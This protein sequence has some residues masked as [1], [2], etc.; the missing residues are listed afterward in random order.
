MSKVSGTDSL[1]SL[2]NLG[3][4]TAQGKGSAEEGASSFAAMLQGI[5]AEG[6][7]GGTA[8]ILP[9][10]PAATTTAAEVDTAALTT[11]PADPA[12]GA[13][14]DAAALATTAT[15]SADSDADVADSMTAP[16]TQDAV[17]FFEDQ[18]AL[19]NRFAAAADGKTPTSKTSNPDEQATHPALRTSTTDS[20]EP[21][22]AKG[23]KAA[24]AAIDAGSAAP[25][26]EVPALKASKSLMALADHTPEH[27]G[28]A[29]PQD[30]SALPAAA[31]A[32]TL[33]DNSAN[34]ALTSASSTNPRDTTRSTTGL[35]QAATFG[36]NSVGNGK[37]LPLSGKFLSNGKEHS[38]KM[39]QAK[40]E[41]PITLA[42]FTEVSSLEDSGF[43]F[44]DIASSFFTPADSESAATVPTGSSATAFDINASSESLVEGSA[45]E[46]LPESATAMLDS[47]S[48][49]GSYA[50]V[51][52]TATQLSMLHEQGV[53]K[54]HIRLHPEELGSL[55]VTITVN[56]GQAYIQFV[57]ATPEAREL[58]QNS[59][60]NLRELLQQ[61]GLALAE[62]N[63][64]Q[65]DAQKDQGLEQNSQQG[66]HR[67]SNG[68]EQPQP[69]SWMRPAAQ[70]RS[71]IDYYI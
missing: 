43:S 60:P 11:A 57:T 45:P 55:D 69:H 17:Q 46:L 62:G 41:S 26:A 42:G 61:S 20:N 47:E 30:A 66:Q 15:T 36:A 28:E 23:R 4:N 12:A 3:L 1:G 51:E 32:A 10:E 54:A 24:S 65:G 8:A 31:S 52:D 50:W 38:G 19:H 70:S 48:T 58:L 33:A 13:V 6:D 25:A 35:N 37:G 56:E 27:D 49:M 7:A 67:F 59:L 5:P 14:I 29:E 22:P 39:T 16:G 21:A 9:E 68:N 44:E 71:Q 40:D 2:L 53:E 64:S 34:A 18:L 63:I